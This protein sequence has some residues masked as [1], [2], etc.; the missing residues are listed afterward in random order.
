MEKPTSKQAVSI[1]PKAVFGLR[2]DV[3]GNIHFDNGR[4]VIYPVA[5]VL[6]F[7]DVETMQQKFLR[8]VEKS[9]PTIIAI[10]P[11]RKLLAVAEKMPDK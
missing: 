3:I 5:G 9:Q 1:V 8:F 4:T 2:T 6:A 7:M 10:S 11:N